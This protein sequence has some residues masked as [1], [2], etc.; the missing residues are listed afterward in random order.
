M[1]AV[2][3]NVI[4]DVSPGVKYGGIGAP[5]ILPADTSALVELLEPHTPINGG[6]KHTI[7]VVGGLDPKAVAGGVIPT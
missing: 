2:P 4:V 3:V 5:D 7:S 6:E 1:P